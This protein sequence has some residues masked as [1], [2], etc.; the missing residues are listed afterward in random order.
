MVWYAPSPSVS[1]ARTSTAPLSS[2]GV[3]FLLW[4]TVFVRSIPA[5]ID[6]SIFKAPYV[7]E[8]PSLSAAASGNNKNGTFDPEKGFG[9]QATSSSTVAL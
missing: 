1:L 3:V 8:E 6:G 4:I 9:S 2:T 7:P 5:F